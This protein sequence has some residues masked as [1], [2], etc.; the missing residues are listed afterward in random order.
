MPTLESIKAAALG[1]ALTNKG[2]ES[3]KYDEY[4][5]NLKD[6]LAQNGDSI[7]GEP[8]P[9]YKEGVKSPAGYVIETN[10][11][12][13]V[14]YHGTQFGKVFGSGGTEIRHDLQTEQVNMQFGDQQLG[15]HKGFKAE[16]DASKESL[17]AALKKVDTSKGVSISGHSLGGAV[18]QIAA[19]DATANPKD[20]PIKIN[21]VV[22]FGGPRVLS[23]EAA[24]EYNKLRL[25]EKT[26]RIKQKWDPVPRLVPKSK[27][28]A[29]VGNKI[30]VDAGT[31][32]VHSGSVY[33]KIGKKVLNE[34][35]VKNARSSDEPVT[36]ETY[37]DIVMRVTKEQFAAAIKSVNGAINIA[38]EYL[39]K[40]TKLVGK[41]IAGFMNRANTVPTTTVTPN[42]QTSRDSLSH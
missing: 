38:H 13:M 6:Q 16:Y 14:C 26:M 11:Q 39:S 19:L 8:I 4:L 7:V 37:L 41:M 36:M 12:V 24:A 40:N 18:A 22:T 17:Y 2:P 30:S 34:D 20:P 35:H 28:Y 42:Q 25:S 32:S 31:N 10:N 33:R 5:K 15:V 1:V 29:H 3:Q 9:F 23:N 21:E 27:N